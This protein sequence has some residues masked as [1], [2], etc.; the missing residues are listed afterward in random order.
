MGLF[1]DAFKNAK[2]A[3]KEGFRES[4]RQI[5]EKRLSIADSAK[6]AEKVAKKTEKAQKRGKNS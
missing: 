1:G 2:I 6:S 5:K 4:V 3:G